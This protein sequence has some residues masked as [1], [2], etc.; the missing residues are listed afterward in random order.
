MTCQN[1]I[2]HDETHCS[3]WSMTFIL[4]ESKG[5]YL[6]LWFVKYENHPSIGRL[7]IIVKY[8]ARLFFIACQNQ[9]FHDDKQRSQRS[10]TFILHKSKDTYLMLRIVKHENHPSLGRML[11]IVKTFIWHVFYRKP[12]HP[13]GN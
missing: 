13:N 8:L 5:A 7:L 2:F 9:M 12:P 6:I 11:I 1:K 3:W 4:H 10:M